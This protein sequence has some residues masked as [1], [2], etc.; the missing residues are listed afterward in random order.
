M[1]EHD[2][3]VGKWSRDT[4]HLEDMQ[5]ARGHTLYVGGGSCMHGHTGDKIMGDTYIRGGSRT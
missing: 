2:V 3:H 4:G 1:V 5:V